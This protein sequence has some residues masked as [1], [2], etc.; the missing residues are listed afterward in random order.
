MPKT[1][2]P[3]KNDFTRTE[4]A[5][6]GFTEN[7]EERALIKKQ[8][9]HLGMDLFSN[10]GFNGKGIRIAIFDGGFPNVDIKSA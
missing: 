9:L 7:N 5:N 6:N 2:T 3:E 8:T 1:K 4:I 10:K